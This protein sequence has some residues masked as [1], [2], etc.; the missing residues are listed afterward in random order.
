MVN[1]FHLM[2]LAECWSTSREADVVM[3]E[4]LFA[5][6][7]TKKDI[8]T[9]KDERWLNDNVSIG[10]HVTIRFNRIINGVEDKLITKSLWLIVS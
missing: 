2:K 1:I 6:D 8:R 5:V 9:L 4:D 10:S 3:R 7:L